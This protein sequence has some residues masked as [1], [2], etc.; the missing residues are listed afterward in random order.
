MT[1]SH[2]FRLS[3]SPRKA[4]HSLVGR[5]SGR[6]KESE[7]PHAVTIYMLE[8]QICQYVLGVSSRRLN[9]P[10]L[11]TGAYYD[12]RGNERRT[13]LLS[14]SVT[15][16]INGYHFG[17]IMFVLSTR[18]NLPSYAESLTLRTNTDFCQFPASLNGVMAPI[19]EGS[20]EDWSKG[21]GLHLE[22]GDICYDA[23]IWLVEE[24][25]ARYV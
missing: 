16:F 10:L 2:Q 18:L 21:D 12:P 25:D 22:T 5:L 15:S 23:Q 6:C 14:T 3:R 7:S 20:G 8:P 17:L 4:I 1:A 24:R 9:E 13:H 11:N 19:H